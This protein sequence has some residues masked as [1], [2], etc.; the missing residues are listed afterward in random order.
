MYNIPSAA[1]SR[2]GGLKVTW[3]IINLF[4]K[5]SYSPTFENIWFSIT[6]ALI[7]NCNTPKFLNIAAED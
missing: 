5:C 2:H 4:E 7:P 3:C 6:E 1:A